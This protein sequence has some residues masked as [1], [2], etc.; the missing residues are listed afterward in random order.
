MN[1]EIRTYTNLL[2]QG[3]IQK[4]YRGIISF[5]AELRNR[6]ANEFSKARLSAL[7]PGYMDMTYFAF[8]TKELANQKLKIAIV[9][10]HESS[11]FELWLSGANKNVQ[12]KYINMFTNKDIKNYV[13]SKSAPGV[14]SI[15]EY[16]VIDCPNFDNIDG[17]RIEIK[18]ALVRFCQDIDNLLN[19]LY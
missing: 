10:L 16:H 14:D 13:L 7:Y 1:K 19:Q 4:A 2:S 8:V 6:F 9:Y 5:M 11:A 12:A 3:E 18:K 17:M 15:L